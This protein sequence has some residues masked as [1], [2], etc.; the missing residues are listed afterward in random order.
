[1]GV[2]AEFDV[3]VVDD[4]VPVAAPVVVEE[5]FND[6]PNFFV[7]ALF[8]FASF[9]LPSVVAAGVA[10]FTSPAPK[11]TSNILRSIEFP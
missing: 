10:K 1:V 5:G 9:P 6:A 3:P 2:P 4:V 7:P 8:T 11:S